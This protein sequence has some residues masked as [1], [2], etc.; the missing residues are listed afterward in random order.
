VDNKEAEEDM[1]QPPHSSSSKAAHSNIKGTLVQKLK[2]SQQTLSCNGHS[3]TNSLSD[4]TDDCKTLVQNTL[5]RLQR[6]CEILLYTVQRHKNEKIMKDE[7]LK[8]SNIP[9]C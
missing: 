3:Y 8:K 6:S 7:D 5:T 1:Q 2:N 9:M 4:R